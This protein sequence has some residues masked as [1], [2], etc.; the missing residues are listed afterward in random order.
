MKSLEG[1]GEGRGAVRFKSLSEGLR[2]RSNRTGP[3]K[4]ERVSG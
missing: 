2:P 3:G 1:R 4:L